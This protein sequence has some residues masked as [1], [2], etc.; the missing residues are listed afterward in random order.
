MDSKG[1]EKQLTANSIH[2]GNRKLSTLFIKIKLLN[3]S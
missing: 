1:K 3:N 2:S